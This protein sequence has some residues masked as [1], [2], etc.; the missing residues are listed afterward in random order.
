[1]N[2][3]EQL[4]NMSQEQLMQEVMKAEQATV[5]LNKI[6]LRV[7]AKGG[8]QINDSRPLRFPLTP[9]AEF[10]VRI[11][12]SKEEIEKFIV[13][14]QKVLSFKYGIERLGIPAP[15]KDQVAVQE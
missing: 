11:L 12:D 5:K 13:D 9:Y 8:V 15:P 2:R 4:K 1:M 3:L 14:N 7:G 6:S 10:L